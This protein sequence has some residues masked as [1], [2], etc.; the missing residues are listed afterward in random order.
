MTALSTMDKNERRRQRNREAAQKSY[1]KKKSENKELEKIAAE[2]E[3]EQ[4]KLHR[5]IFQLNTLL[6]A[7][8]F[9]L[10]SVKCVVSHA[11]PSSAGTAGSSSPPASFRGRPTSSGAAQATPK[12][13]QGHASMRKQKSK[14][15]YPTPS[16]DRSRETHNEVPSEQQRATGSSPWLI[17]SKASRSSGPSQ[18]QKTKNTGRAPPENHSKNAPCSASTHYDNTGKA[19]AMAPNQGNG[20]NLEIVQRSRQ[21]V[22]TQPQSNDEDRVFTFTGDQQQGRMSNIRP[23]GLLAF[24]SS[25]APSDRHWNTGD[26]I[27]TLVPSGEEYMAVQQDTPSA[28]SNTAS[29]D[30]M[31]L[32]A[33]MDLTSATGQL[34]GGYHP[35]DAFTAA[36][37]LITNASTMSSAAEVMPVTVNSS[38]LAAQAHET[39]MVIPHTRSEAPGPPVAAFQGASQS[40]MDFST[41]TMADETVSTPCSD[42]ATTGWKME[43]EKKAMTVPPGTVTG[44][45]SSPA[46][47]FKKMEMSGDIAGAVLYQNCPT[48]LKPSAEPCSSEIG[49]DEDML[50]EACGGNKLQEL[51]DHMNVQELEIYLDE[52]YEMTADIHLS[53]ETQLK[54]V[55]LEDNNNYCPGQFTITHPFPLQAELMKEVRHPNQ[56]ELIT[57]SQMVNHLIYESAVVKGN[58]SMS[59]NG[60]QSTM[61]V[62][63]VKNVPGKAEAMRG[64]DDV[65]LSQRLESPLTINVKLKNK[66]K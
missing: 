26:N 12:S 46:H 42:P 10:T 7:F 44:Q 19:G 13:T 15:I 32:L 58:S 51:L 59:N 39:P 14:G 18:S 3:E 62:V 5:Q 49:L 61:G 48:N 9:V 6:H 56:R 33:D 64:R 29:P 11:A 16:Q 24:P 36:E 60:R 52:D 55:P 21:G 66:Y 65:S 30:V 57:K 37:E 2:R 54:A 1:L 25:S 53:E 34:F 22:V 17:Q 40:A 35:Q 23:D 47:I 41:V 20:F 4:I 8:V 45:Q 28:D 63:Q 43:V 50:L 27:S 38:N 31:D